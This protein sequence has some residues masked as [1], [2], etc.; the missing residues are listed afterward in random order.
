MM[1][2]V[3]LRMVWALGLGGERAV[4]CAQTQPEVA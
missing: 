3:L 2:A 1:S 4:N